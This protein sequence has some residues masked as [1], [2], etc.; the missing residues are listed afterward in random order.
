MAKIFV[1]ILIFCGEALAIYSEM[2]GAKRFG[3]GDTAFW[4]LFFRIFVVMAAGG[5]LLVAGYTLG[6]KAFQNI[7]V[8]SAI[9]ITSILLIEPILAYGF[10]R[11]MPTYGALA[12]LLLGA[13]GFCLALFWK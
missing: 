11:Q 12:G 13:A 2:L 9:S 1:I 6:Y 8:V 3:L 4:P 10:F 5:A 7:W